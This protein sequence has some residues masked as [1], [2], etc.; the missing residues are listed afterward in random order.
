MRE[1]ERFFQHG[2]K[3]GYTHGRIHGLIEGRA[4]GK[5]KG[6]ELWEEVGY[7]K[8][9]A[10]LLRAA[11]DNDHGSSYVFDVRVVA[12]TDLHIVFVFAS[13]RVIHHIS[14]LLSAIDRFPVVNPGPKAGVGPEDQSTTPDNENE[15]D[16]SKLLSQIRSR[17]RAL[18][19]VLG[20]PIRLRSV[21]TG[22]DPLLSGDAAL[23]SIIH[24]PKSNKVWPIEH[25]SPA[26]STLEI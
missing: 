2:Y 8:G 16:V 1:S 7:Y 22:Q 6:M 19:S 11:Y 9:F 17:H 23:E 3:D 4:A 10:A 14:S 24:A 5:D 20:V 18:C 25:Q 21:A 13:R 12:V 26:N 15:C